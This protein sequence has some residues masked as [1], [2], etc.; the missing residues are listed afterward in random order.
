M[1]KMKKKGLTTEYTEKEEIQTCMPREEPARADGADR[2][3]SQDIP[4]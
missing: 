3:N 4:T 2:K 1:E